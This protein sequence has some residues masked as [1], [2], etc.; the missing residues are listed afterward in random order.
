MNPCFAKI[1]QKGLRREFPLI[2]LTL[3]HLGEDYFYP[4]PGGRPHRSPSPAPGCGPVRRGRG[5][6]KARRREKYR[7]TV[8]CRPTP[9]ELDV[10]LTHPA[11]IMPGAGLDR[12]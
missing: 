7:M 6:F 4:E 10:C 9:D 3:K 12:D 1:R 5:F 2:L 11:E 8:I